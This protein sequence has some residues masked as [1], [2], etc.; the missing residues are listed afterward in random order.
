MPV[1]TLSHLNKYF[2]DRH[3]LRDV[4]FTVYEGEKVAVVGPNGSGKTTLFQVITGRL[5]YDSGEFALSSGK[6]VGIIDQIP[7]FAPECSVEDVLRSAFSRLYALQAQLQSLEAQMAADPSPALL[8]RYGALSSRFESLDGYHV[9]HRINRV[10]NGLEIPDAMREKPFSVLSGGEKTRVNLARIILEDTDILLLDEPT[11]HLDLN[12]VGW[13][14]DFLAAYKGT[15][16]TISHDRYFLDQC[17]DRIIELDG[18]VCDLYA[19]SYSYYAVE[20]E[21]RRQARLQEYARQTAAIRDLQERSARMHQWGTEKMHKRAASIDKRI[22]RMKVG[23]RPKAEKKLHMTFGDPD[24]PTEELL[25]VKHI[26][27]SFDGVPVLR[28]LT[29]TVRNGDRIAIVGD[30]GTGK[31]T[32]L[33]IILGQET[34]DAGTL[35]RADGLKISYLPQQVSFENPGRNLID[36]LLFEKN[37][38]AQTARNRLGAFHFSGEAQQKT[39]ASLSGGE[40]SRLKLCTIMYDPLNF[41]ILDEPTNHL[42]IL[43]RE[44]IEEA[45]EGYEGTMLFVSHDR[46]FISRFANRILFIQNGRITDF[47]GSY[48]AFLETQAQKTV[49]AAAPKEKK[50]RP[51]RSG[52]TKVLAKRQAVLEREISALEERAAALDEQIAA[53]A[54]DPDKLVGLLADQDA[55]QASLEE[56]LTEWEAVSRSLDE[57][58][59]DES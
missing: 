35:R 31:T 16:V 21:R 37:L 34:A 55:L 39:V 51:K 10:C 38:T 15:V 44:W 32:L 45:I 49:P 53:F 58:G 22:A 17:C 47:S 52:G 43:S 20:R 8:Q 26:S 46:Y 7:S 18:G 24:F 13:L 40:K 5:P 14:G 9:D 2:G 56:K 42:D 25:F 28:D 6:T 50:E 1:L 3:I 54:T 4:S 12:G 48:E 27:K 11:N 23:D 30:N 57:E 36:T 19:G 29:F 33:K 41:L 59:F